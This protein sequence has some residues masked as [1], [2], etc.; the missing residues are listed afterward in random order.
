MQ[1]RRALVVLVP[2]AQPRWMAAPERQ[3]RCAGS[4]QP[5]ARSVTGI[6][7][8]V[9]AGVAGAVVLLAILFLLLFQGV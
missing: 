2:L 4:M 9:V 6:S 1:D 8:G 5:P 7:L 3:P